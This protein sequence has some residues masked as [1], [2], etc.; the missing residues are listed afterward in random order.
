M[1]TTQNVPGE[2]GF[3]AMGGIQQAST[4][5]GFD[6]EPPDQGLCAGGGYVM[7]FIN[8]AL[9]IYDK[10]GTQLL[11]P[12]GSTSVF[13]QP[14]TD[15]FSD[16]RCYYDAPT[17]RWFVQEFIVGTVN[18]AGQQVTPS[19]QFEA[20]SNTQDPTGSYTVFSWDTTDAAT[21]H[22][23]CFG[24]YDNLGADANGIYVT[25][26]EFGITS[27]FNGVRPPLHPTGHRAGQ[28]HQ[29]R[30][31][32]HPQPWAVGDNADG[33]GRPPGRG[34]GQERRPAV[35]VHRG[36]RQRHRVPAVRAERAA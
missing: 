24:D 26:D 30:R 18:S 32:G 5:G 25:T 27:G 13:A 12:I 17:K 11:P 14:T 21:G 22:C 35:P 3:S 28:R 29:R 16:P 7:E 33:H 1:L 4:T 8:N 10:N 2:N 9:A 6:L 36:G 19:V 20:V 15:F 23:P 34:G 31:L